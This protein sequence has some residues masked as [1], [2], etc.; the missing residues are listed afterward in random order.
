VKVLFWTTWSIAAIVT[1]IVVYF[2]FSGRAEGSVSSFNI[3]LWIA[4]LGVV[5]SVT[6]GSLWLY[7][8]KHAVLATLVAMLLAV[9]GLLAGLFLLIVLISHPRWN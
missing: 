5:G 7:R 1:A 6:G 4:I 2:F 3:V 8:A 9:P